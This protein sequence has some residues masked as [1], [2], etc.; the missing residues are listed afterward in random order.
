MKINFLLAVLGTTDAAFSVCGTTGSI[1]H[2]INLVED[3]RPIRHFIFKHGH[4]VSA[5]RIADGTSWS[6]EVSGVGHLDFSLIRREH[7]ELV[8]THHENVSLDL[9]AC[10]NAIS[11]E[12][13]TLTLRDGDYS[14]S[15]IEGTNVRLTPSITTS[16][17][18]N[19]TLASGQPSKFTM[20][21]K[22]SSST[23]YGKLQGYGVALGPGCSQLFGNS[24]IWL[25]H[26][27]DLLLLYRS[28]STVEL[29]GDG[30]YCHGLEG[31]KTRLILTVPDYRRQLF[32]MT[33][34]REGVIQ[35]TDLLQ[36]HKGVVLLPDFIKAAFSTGRSGENL[37]P[38]PVFFDIGSSGGI[39]TIA[40][41]EFKSVDCAAPNDGPALLSTALKQ[42][43]TQLIAN[44]PFCFMD[45]STEIRFTGDGARITGE[46]RKESVL[47]VVFNRSYIITVGSEKLV[48]DSEGG[49][50]GALRGS[51][52]TA[53]AS[54]SSVAGSWC[55]PEHKTIFIPPVTEGLRHPVF[56]KWA[57]E[58]RL[59]D[60]VF[61][62]LNSGRSLSVSLDEARFN[63][64]RGRI[65]R[66]AKRICDPV[67]F[68]DRS[69]CEV[70]SMID[71]ETRGGMIHAGGKD[72][73]PFDLKNGI[74]KFGE[75]TLQISDLLDGTC[76]HLRYRLRMMY[77]DHCIE[78]KH[79]R[80]S[81]GRLQVDDVAVTEF[82][83]VKVTNGRL[84][85]SIPK[86]S[87][88]PI[89]LD[90]RDVPVVGRKGG[91]VDL[92]GR[93]FCDLHHMKT[94]YFKENGLVEEVSSTGRRQS[95]YVASKDGFTALINQQRSVALD[96]IPP[97]ECKTFEEQLNNLNTTRCFM[98]EYT[99]SVQKGKW[100]I[101]GEEVKPLDHYWL[102]S[103]IVVRLSPKVLMI[104]KD[105]NLVGGEEGACKKR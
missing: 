14:G 43:I 1:R 72:P 49:I 85:I 50:N 64:T 39:V 51:C 78:G 21:V 54:V 11:E 5:H 91:C 68:G 30:L 103:A 59:F 47:P 76:S 38:F 33:V 62:P 93:V 19:P 60:P 53:K 46:G 31:S 96:R 32:R 23:C 57:L 83:V 35:V 16:I 75:R 89:E 100:L 34:N 65:D 92:T 58:E 37:D 73:V 77:Y 97:K 70:Q 12:Q 101:S 42:R 90:D 82:K 6:L 8:L 55:L 4:L 25:S 15:L 10:D 52:K 45:F 44:G 81:G 40:D 13:V 26:K 102:R 27:H 22:G 20:T 67:T 80:A 87:D 63:V 95:S 56:L 94:L 29:V 66:A 74:L 28:S 18:S 98:D 61:A 24:L 79:V 105:G 9:V 84:F 104:V 69:F 41:L 48:L 3:S 71:Y 99:V 86:V 2:Q 7:D 88:R 36:V 17:S